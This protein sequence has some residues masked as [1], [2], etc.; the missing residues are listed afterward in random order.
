LPP[1]GNANFAAF[2]FKE[3]Y[4]S[5]PIQP[6][7][8]KLGP[9]A[10]L[11]QNVS[12]DQPGEK[13]PMS[14]Q[15]SLS[16]Q[17]E[18]AGDWL[19]DLA[20]AGNRGSHLLAGG[21]E[22]NQLDP[23]HW[24]LGIA[25]QDQAPNPYAGR[26]PGAL[27]GA[28]IT[29]AQS[30]RPYPYYNAI[31]VRNPHNGSSIYHA[32]MFS[33][34]KRFSKG[35]VLLASYTKAKLISDSV[36]TPINF[37]PVEQVGIVGYQD[38]KFDRRSERSIDPTDVSQRLVVSG[39]Y[40]FPFGKGRLLDSSNRLVNGLI[41]GWQINSITTIQTGVPVVVRGASN[42]R[43]DRPNSTGKTA[44]LD[45]RTAEQ[46]FDT[47]AFVNPPSFTLGNVGRVLPDVRT[48]GVV[49][50]DL[51]L[52]KDTFVRESVRVQFRA[53]AFNFPNHVNLGAP[54]ATFAPGPDGLN[55]SATFGT[56]TSA[57]DPRLLQF[58]LKLIF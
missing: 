7:G 34:E 4:P 10:F 55:R 30:L 37:G 14:Q 50:L 3:G 45:K 27:G 13:V 18:F 32:L 16:L 54:S 41:G 21:Y 42:F 2:Q 57:R 6:Q 23:Q 31:T 47:S 1:G 56:I 58:G 40:E 38:G 44:K 35:L 48:P 51:S 36:V 43:A 17:H 19:V 26:V 52:I 12:F 25:L 11:G 39:I 28:T 15:W 53:E 22:L 46:W 29:R 49:N 24:S 20:Y 5:P 8:A 9:S 33:A